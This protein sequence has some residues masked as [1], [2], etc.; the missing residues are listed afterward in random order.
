MTSLTATVVAADPVPQVHLDALMDNAAQVVGW[1]I[2][3]TAPGETVKVYVGGPGQ[4]AMSVVDGTAPLGVPVTYQLTVIYPTST[5]YADAGPVTITGTVGCFLTSPATGVTLAVEISTWPSRKRTARQAVLAVLGRPDPVGVTDAHNT[6]LGEWTLISRSDA[7]TAALTDLLT[8][9]G[10]VVLRTQPGSSIASCT[11]LVGDVDETRYS[12]AA[13]DPRRLFEVEIQEIGAVPAT[14]YPLAATLG[15]LA[16]YA[17][18]TTL[19]QLADLRP[20]LLA[21]SQIETG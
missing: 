10:V 15:G 4:S 6:P 19:A 7:Y 21:L 13:G 5:V 11:A 12:T 16:V 18:I 9:Q 14:A 3:R 8:D 17:G 1:S 2:T 20:T